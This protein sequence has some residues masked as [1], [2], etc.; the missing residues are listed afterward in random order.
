M[1]EFPRDLSH[2]E[3]SRPAAFES[4]LG[5]SIVKGERQ[6]LGEYKV[7]DIVNFK[8]VN[9]L[10]FGQAEFLDMIEDEDLKLEIVGISD[11]DKLIV[12]L[13]VAEDFVEQCTVEQL[14]SSRA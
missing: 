4:A 11:E 8:R 1:N 3:S 12:R 13:T 5:S 10:P 14:N 7:G 9:A 2:H 6:E